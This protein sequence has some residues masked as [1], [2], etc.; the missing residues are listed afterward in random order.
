MKKH[1]GQPRRSS[2][3]SKNKTSLAV[4]KFPTKQ[5][6]WM[7]ELRA[8]AYA[9]E[10][11]N[12]M[13]ARAVLNSLAHPLRK[14]ASDRALGR[15]LH[16]D[17]RTIGRWRARL[18]RPHRRRVVVSRHQFI[19]LCARI[20]HMNVRVVSRK[21]LPEDIRKYVIPAYQALHRFQFGPRTMPAKKRKRRSAR[22]HLRPK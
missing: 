1:S 8:R 2:P 20:G 6:K 22:P 13:I 4:G 19:R 14:R 3:S 5:E 10:G 18:N 7:A 16:V 21:L 15:R 17:H 11:R 12:A 9:R